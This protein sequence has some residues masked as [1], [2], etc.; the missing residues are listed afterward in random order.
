MKGRRWWG[1]LV[2]QQPLDGDVHAVR[3][4]LPSNT[5]THKHRAAHT[6]TLTHTHTFSHHYMDTSETIPPCMHIPYKH[7]DN[8]HK[9]TCPYVY[10]GINVHTHG[11]YKPMQTHTVLPAHLQVHLVTYWRS[12]EKGNIALYWMH[13][14]FLVIILSTVDKNKCLRR[15]H[16]SGGLTQLELP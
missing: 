4:R 1:Y 10:A 3:G 13:T 8:A 2:C 12:L 14:L 7:T 15:P 16:V 9:H 11:K 5:C 6:G